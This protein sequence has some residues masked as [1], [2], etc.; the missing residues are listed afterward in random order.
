L[1]FQERKLQSVRNAQNS[2]WR[3]LGLTAWNFG[4]FCSKGC[5]FRLLQPAPEQISIESEKLYIVEKN[6]INSVD[7]PPSCFGRMLTQAKLTGSQKTRGLPNRLVPLPDRAM[8]KIKKQ[9]AS[10]IFVIL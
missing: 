1:L 3:C 6:I 2:T 9:C 4:R 10:S 7:N 5:N 8:P